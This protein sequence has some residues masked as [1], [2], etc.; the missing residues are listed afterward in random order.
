VP[1]A[2][3]IGV[4]SIVVAMVSYSAGVWSAFRKRGIGRMQVALLWLGVACD[5]GGTAM[6]ALQVGYYRL[7][8]HGIIGTVAIAGMAAVAAF[9]TYALVK[10][11]ER[12]GAK[13]A[14]WAVAPWV[15]WVAMFV[16]G[17]IARAPRR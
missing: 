6:M 16:W 4:L 13:I 10:A 1:V 9:A 12:L 14:S 11:D 17:M 3:M 5:A 8:P 7:D 15:F 2:I